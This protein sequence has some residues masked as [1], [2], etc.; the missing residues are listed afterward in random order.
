M[1]SPESF[2][3]GEWIRDLALTRE[4]V[5]E[6]VGLARERCERKRSFPASLDGL[7]RTWETGGRHRDRFL[8]SRPESTVRLSRPMIERG[9]D[10]FARLLRPDVARSRR[11]SQLAGRESK[12]LRAE[13]LGVVLHVVS[14]NVFF[15]PAESLLAGLLTGNVNLVKR[16]TEGGDFLRFFLHSLEEYAPEL[17]A[18][19]ALLHWRG[20]EEAVEEILG[21]CV[22][23]IVVAADSETIA[24]YRRLA[25]PFTALLEFGPRVSVAVVSQAALDDVD[26]DGLARDVALWDQ[27]ACT[28]AQ[29][30]YV[31]GEA[32]AARL[33]ERI[34]EALFSLGRAL[35][36]GEAPLDERIEVGR[37][38]DTARFAEAMGRA[39]VF[40]GPAGWLSTVVLDKDPDFQPSPLRRSVRVKS[41]AGVP[42]LLDSLRPVRGML[43][44]VGLAVAPEERAEYEEGLVGVGVRRLCRVGTMNE[45]PP[46]ALHDGTMELARLVRWVERAGET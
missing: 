31:Q 16:P 20:G 26:V 27:L 34:A 17:T 4:R 7:R 45:P 15:G 32:S 40:P 43:Q 14:G 42:E 35:P 37:F 46:D 9:L 33:A 10:H 12:A 8:A 22:D 6:I 5:R 1:T 13:P 41:Y 21:R 38:R 44:T 11:A 23:A 30:I 3:F 36:E 29:C 25:S 19:T 2:L 24:S 28:A 39:R 18:S